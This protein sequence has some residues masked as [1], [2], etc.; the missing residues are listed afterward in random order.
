MAAS[1]NMHKIEALEPISSQK[2]AEVT[3]REPVLSQVMR[4]ESSHL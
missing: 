1:F 3:A 2:Q 4:L